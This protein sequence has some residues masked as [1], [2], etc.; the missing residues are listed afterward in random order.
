MDDKIFAESEKHTKTLKRSKGIA[1]GVG[2][3]DIGLV[4][5]HGLS[6][7]QAYLLA[8]GLGHEGLDELPQDREEAWH[9]DDK[10]SVQPLRPVSS[11][12]SCTAD[13][14]QS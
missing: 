8:C 11:N 4:G 14:S 6:S 9:V 5:T 1:M 10:S 13:P 12:H 3:Q 2:Y 7:E